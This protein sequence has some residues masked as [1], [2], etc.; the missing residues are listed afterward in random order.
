M[1]SDNNQS[2]SYLLGLNEF[3]EN[4]SPAQNEQTDALL[5]GLNMLP[6]TSP[7]DPD[8]AVSH[9]SQQLSLWTNANFSFDGPM[10]HALIGDDEKDG[11][12]KK[13]NACS[14]TSRQVV[15]TLTLPVTRCAI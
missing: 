13:K 8:D 6:S 14:G 10:G 11:A 9:F 4:V 2:I 1:S 3:Q 5:A 12:A 7:Q 15:H